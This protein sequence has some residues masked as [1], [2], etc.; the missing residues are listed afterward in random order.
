[1]LW[2]RKLAADLGRD[3][4]RVSK[5]LRVLRESGAVASK[6]GQNDARLEC[7]FIPEVFRQ[8][9]GVVDYGFCRLTFEPA[10][11]RSAENR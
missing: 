1:L 8:Q 9:P 7:Y 10:A 11:P 2:A 3:L 5:H 4:D 6:R